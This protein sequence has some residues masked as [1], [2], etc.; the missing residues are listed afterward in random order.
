LLV[1]GQ[2]QRPAGGVILL[3]GQLFADAKSILPIVG[4][5]DAGAEDYRSGFGF[6]FGFQSR[7]NFR[8]SAI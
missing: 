1:S 2:A 5:V 7:A 4:E 3:A 8:A 6:G